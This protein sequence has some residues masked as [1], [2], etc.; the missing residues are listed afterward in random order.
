MSEVSLQNMFQSTGVHETCGVYFKTESRWVVVILS[1]DK[2]GTTSITC[3]R[4]RTV[5]S[6]DFLVHF[7]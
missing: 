2:T 1:K 3:Q 6:E 7:F 4:N 5:E